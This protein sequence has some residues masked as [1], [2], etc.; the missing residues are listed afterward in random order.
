[1][2]LDFGVVPPYLGTIFLGAGWTVLITLLA[3]AISL[4][5]GIGLALVQ[6]YAARWVRR[7]VAVP[8]FLILGTPLLL[9]LF[10]VYYGLG[11]VGII[12]PAFWTGVIGLGLH[13]AV[14]NAD[15]LRA[16]IQSVDSGQIEAARSLGFGPYEAMLRFVLPQALL[17]AA[18]QIGNNIIV[19]LKDSVL[20]SALGVMEM[21]LAAQL[22][23][24]RTF[25]PFEFYITV[26]AIF[27]VLNL[28]LEGALARL[29]RRMEAIL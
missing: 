20:L 27:Y 16:A 5:G 8:V 23:I 6:A 13:Y 26:A 1:M 28:A 19:L 4:L 10:V 18:P 15:V 24:S 2:N 7:V 21:V 12:L 14:Y 22:A 9:Q 29:A 3:G 11:Q 25:R 17:R